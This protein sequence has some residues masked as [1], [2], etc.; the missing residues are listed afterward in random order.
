VYEIPD[1]N[2]EEEFKL[3][4]SCLQHIGFSDEEQAQIL[5]IVVA[6]LLLG[7]VDFDTLEKPGVGDISAV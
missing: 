5:N 7:N 4:L 2:D 3:T 6:V 1:I